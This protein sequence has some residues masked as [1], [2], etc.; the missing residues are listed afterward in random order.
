[1]NLKTFKRGV[2]PDYYKEFTSAK[3]IEQA[4]LPKRVIIPLE[5][6]IGEP[7]R[8]LVKKGDVVEEGQKIGEANAFVSA[9]I[10][11]SISG[12]VREVALQPYPAGG[13]VLSVVI[14]GDGSKKQWN[15]GDVALDLDNLQPATLREIVREAGIVGMGGA[16]F[17][18][19][20][21]LSPPGESKVDSVILNAC[22]CEPYLT[23]DHRL[24]LEEPEK[25]LWGLKAIIKAVG[26]ET[27]FVGIEDNKPD[28][29]EALTMA[30]AK[31][32]PHIKVVVLETKYPQGAEKMLINAVL[33]RKVPVG[34]LPFNVGV[35]V[36]NVATAFS[37]YEAVR[38]KK[39][40]IQR[41]VTVSGNGVG[42]PKNLRVRIGTTFGE[43]LSL[44]G[45]IT[46][47]GEKEVLSGGP[48]MGIAQTTLNVP[49]VKGTAGITVLVGR[50]IKPSEYDP[51]IRCASCVE[52]CPM[53]LM[54]YRIGDLGRLARTAEFKAWSGTSCME[55]GCC[56][57]VC[58]S[59]RPLVEW[60]RVG[61]I[62]LRESERGE[63]A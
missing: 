30:A 6:H 52:V 44:C 47:E 41:V 1:M 26:A 36:H 27:G 23:A 62:K 40:L 10:H 57:F 34:K 24:M 50:E 15:G 45:G 42:E 58:P 37:I 19:V 56:S 21:K 3:P 11:A 61:K 16:A 29:A 14:E 63:A 35:V 33:G 17:P 2:H 38:Y 25:I 18:T 32:A 12:K 51:C 31:V 59:K 48:M 53:G 22:E 5:Q 20:V 49:V 55:C 13:R 8:P 43:I 46:G 4:P 28:A 60:I 54:P 7:C 39:P 9:P